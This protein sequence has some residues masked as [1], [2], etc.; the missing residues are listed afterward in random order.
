MWQRRRVGPYT[1][2]DT[3]HCDGH[4]DSHRLVPNHRIRCRKCDIRFGLPWL[5]VVA[6]SRA[7]ADGHIQRRPRSKGRGKGGRG[8]QVSVEQPSANSQSRRPSTPRRARGEALGTSSD[9]VGINDSPGDFARHLERIAN[10]SSLGPEASGLVTQAKELVASKVVQHA[11]PAEGS[12]ASYAT[13]QA[14]LAKKDS[15]DA[16]VNRAFKRLQRHLALAQ[17]YDGERKQ[18]QAEFVDAGAAYARAVEAHNN[19]LKAASSVAASDVAR[20]PSPCFR[21]CH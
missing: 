3:P 1:L 17:K 7:A 5:P 11:A 14:A 10:F 6:A 19:V 16:R 9:Q 18:A 12:D 2:C 8:R 20:A 15:A 21:K 4:I 13:V